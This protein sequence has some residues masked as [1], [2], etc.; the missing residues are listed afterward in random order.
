[1][2][3]PAVTW[4]FRFSEPTVESVAVVIRDKDDQQLAK[5]HSAIT[6]E[7][8]IKVNIFR[9]LRSMYIL[10]LVLNEFCGIIKMFP[11]F[12]TFMIQP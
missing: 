5:I 12:I 11:S 9:I 1:M 3:G 2:R 7:E 6:V 10:T 8:V 4:S